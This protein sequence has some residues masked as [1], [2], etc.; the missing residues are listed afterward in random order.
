MNIVNPILPGFHPD[1]CILRH[2]DFYY[3]ATSTF[4]WFP[5]IALYQSKDLIHW[6][7]IGHVLDRPE[8][9]DMRGL[10]SSEGVWA[11]DLTYCEDDGYFYIS[12]TLMHNWS[13]DGPRDMHNYVTRSRSIEGPWSIPVKIDSGGIDPALFFDEDGRTYWMRNQWEYRAGFDHFAGIVMQE[14]DRTS[15]RVVGEKKTV[16]AGT[17]LG[18]V[19][20]PHVYKRDG[21]Y[22]LLTAEG[23]TFF[24]HAV[25]LARSRSIWGPYE[26]HPENPVMSSQL[27]PNHP[28]QKVGHASLVQAHDGS[29]YLSYLCGRPLPSRGRCILGREAALERVVWADDGWLYRSEP[30][31]APSVVVQAPNGDEHKWEELPAKD[32]FDEP[33]LRTSYQFLRSHMDERY[34]TL[35]ERPGYLRLRGR[36][37][38]TSRIDQSLVAR[39][40]T[41]FVYEAS[42]CME[43]DPRNPNQLAGLIAFYDHQH[44]FYLT[45]TNID[46]PCLTLYCADRGRWIEPIDVVPID[47]GPI[48][49]KARMR[50]D[51]L[52]F[53]YSMDGEAWSDIGPLMDSSIL[54]DDYLI[55]VHFTGAFIG[56]CAN[57]LDGTEIIAD[58]DYFT[59]EDMLNV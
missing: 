36:Q 10:G 20:G 16:F 58:F 53:A 29:W 40:Q 2:Q 56:I 35:T 4:E 17:G 28:L 26:I 18:K 52:R 46:G 19:E 34:C 12:Y 41:S 13:Y 23:G 55:P 45:K 33:K 9:I 14:F 48:H 43:F 49:L 30:G 11:P 32:D 7:S 27:E 51:K 42:T 6:Q 5:A 25:S 37:S 50:Y 8:Q 22:Y 57:D 15:L 1:P 59:Y 47:D 54:S 31:K 38:P 39:R 24:D 21:Y 3:I 44:F